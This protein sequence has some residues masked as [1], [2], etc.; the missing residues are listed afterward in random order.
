MNI[1][2]KDVLSVLIGAAFVGLDIWLISL[3]SSIGLTILII[4]VTAAAFVIA[5]LFLW[6]VVQI[7][8]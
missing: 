3:V 1:I 7:E 2:V 5:L 8:D 4:A 6:E